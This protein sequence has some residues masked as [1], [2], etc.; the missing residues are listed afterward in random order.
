V[1]ERDQGQCAFVGAQGQCRQTAFLEFHH[2]VPFAEGG[3]ATIDNISLRCRQH[4]GHEAQ[5]LIAF[6]VAGFV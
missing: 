4:N 5:Q 6:E 1:W 2:I 3:A